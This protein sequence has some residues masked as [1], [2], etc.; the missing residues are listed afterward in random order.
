MLIMC[1]YNAYSVVPTIRYHT[2]NHGSNRWYDC[3]SRYDVPD[4]H[5]I[6]CI[7]ASSWI[8]SPTMCPASSLPYQILRQSW[9][10]SSVDLPIHPHMCESSSFSSWCQSICR[11]TSCLLVKLGGRKRGNATHGRGLDNN[12]RRGK[13]LRRKGRMWIEG[14][15]K[16]ADVDWERQMK[17]S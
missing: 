11:L 7:A 10:P 4:T 9:S 17:V 13:A 5:P 14:R 12:Q 6:S 2:S 3:M 15:R 8:Y 1:R 16:V